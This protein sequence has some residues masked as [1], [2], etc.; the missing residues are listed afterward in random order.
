MTAVHRRATHED[1]LGLPESVVG[2]IIDGELH[3]QPRPAP[4]HAR[5]SSALGIKVGSPFD[6]GEGN[7]P[8]GWWILNEPELHLG[9][10]ILVPDL[11]GWQREHLP[12]LP[13]TA[14]FEMAPD[15]TCEVLSPVTARTDR[16]QKL[17]GYAAE[18]V[19]HCWLLNPEVRTLEAF[20]NQAGRWLLG[21]WGDQDQAAIDPFAAVTL[22][23]A[24]LWVD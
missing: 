5:I 22:D 14:W 13:N 6:Q 20:A 3:T 19:A 10:D 8:G 21:T 16:V 12:S 23:L 2:E 24:G 11:A 18:G 17:P 15:W 4:A 9:S 7:G 1:L